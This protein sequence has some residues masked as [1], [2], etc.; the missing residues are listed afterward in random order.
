MAYKLA[1][2]DMDGT[3]LN[4]LE[5]LADTLN[6]TLA[7]HGFPE[8]TVPEVKSFIGNGVRHLIMRGAP[9]NTDDVTL[10]DM[11]ADFRKY[12][13]VHCMDKTAP[14]DGITDLLKNLRD[15]GIKTAVISNKADFAVGELC[16]KYFNGLF[17]KAFG[18]RE[19]V[20]RKPAPD[21][22]FE[23]MRFFDCSKDE[24]VYIG[25]SEV[26]LETARRAGIGCIIVDWGYRKAELCLN[27]ENETFVNSTGEILD[28]VINK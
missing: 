18:E 20:P 2:F 23:M 13:K 1:V 12:Y 26:D 21:A 11:Y 22:V 3:I 15:R 10:A 27:G 8:R 6:Y 7:K 16:E 17:D 19:G 9:E 4:T 24:T 25:D 28:T 14:Y 5:D